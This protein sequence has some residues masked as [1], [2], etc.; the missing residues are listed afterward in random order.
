MVPYQSDIHLKKI[1]STTS[2]NTQKLIWDRLIDIQ[3]KSVKIKFLEGNLREELH[4]F[5]VDKHSQTRHNK[6]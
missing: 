3:V 2:H 1:L 5:G 6:L 4:N